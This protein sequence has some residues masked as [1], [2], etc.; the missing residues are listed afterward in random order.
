MSDDLKKLKT[1]LM[2]WKIATISLVVLSIFLIVFSIFFI[3][4]HNDTVNIAR[5]SLANFDEL[6]NVCQK[7]ANKY[8][9]LNSSYAK[10]GDFCVQSV[11]KL[12]QNCDTQLSNLAASCTANSLR[13]TQQ[14]NKESEGTSLSELIK[15]LSL[16]S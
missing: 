4:L 2:W 15:L 14:S 6:S 8:V 11:I 10:L 12:R 3:Y 9:E 7:L 1:E 16:F 13:E 5:Q